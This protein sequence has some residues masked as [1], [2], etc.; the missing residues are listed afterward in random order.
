MKKLS[1]LRDCHL[2]EVSNALILVL[3]KGKLRGLIPIVLCLIFSISIEKVHCSKSCGV[4]LRLLNHHRDNSGKKMPTL[5][6]RVLVSP[7]D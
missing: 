5:A 4:D 1:L 7:L 6:R 3:G 2:C